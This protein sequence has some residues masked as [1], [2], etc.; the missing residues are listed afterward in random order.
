MRLLGPPLVRTAAQDHRGSGVAAGETVRACGEVAGDRL[1]VTERLASDGDE[2]VT[3]A[4]L[5]SPG[6]RMTGHRRLL[7]LTA[8]LLCLVS[9]V[10]GEDPTRLLLPAGGLQRRDRDE[11]FMIRS[12]REL[13]G[14]CSDQHL[15]VNEESPDLSPTTLEKSLLNSRGVSLYDSFPSP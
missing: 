14:S 12:R 7:L 9:T 5:R 11:L 13:H 6:L 3:V 8:A 2:M 15:P 10:Q 1:A 4:P